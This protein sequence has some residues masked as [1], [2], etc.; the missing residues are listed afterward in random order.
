[1]LAA[2][3]ERQGARE[4]LAE[5]R[6]T[7]RKRQEFLALIR[8][9]GFTKTRRTKQFINILSRLA[10]LAEAKCEEYREER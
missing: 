4:K 2:R 10:K 6:F 8:N 9:G 3:R 5:E 1:M 7:A